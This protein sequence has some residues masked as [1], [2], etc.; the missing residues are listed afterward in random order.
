MRYHICY[1]D[2]LR[3]KDGS[4]VNVNDV[5]LNDSTHEYDVGTREKDGRI[6]KVGEKAQFLE[7]YIDE[8]IFVLILEKGEYDNEHIQ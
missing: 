2:T 3:L 1:S 4:I 8:G 5:L 7:D 6:R